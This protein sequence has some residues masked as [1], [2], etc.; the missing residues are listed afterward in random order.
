MIQQIGIMLIWIA[1]TVF[2]WFTF[3]VMLV[4][5][6]NKADPDDK[7][8]NTKFAIF[9]ATVLVILVVGLILAHI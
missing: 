1:S 8:G 7:S 4:H 6:A 5:I 9:F 3:A 2:L